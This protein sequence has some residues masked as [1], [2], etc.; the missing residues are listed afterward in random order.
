MPQD[1]TELPRGMAVKAAA[2]LIAI[3]VGFG[4]VLVWLLFDSSVSKGTSI[5]FAVIGLLPIALFVY[6]AVGIAYFAIT[7]R[8]IAGANRLNSFAARVS[9]PL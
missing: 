4:A 8:R 2:T 1:V 5:T 9:R 7:G 6:F 3:S